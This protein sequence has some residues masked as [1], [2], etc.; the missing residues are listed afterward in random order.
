MVSLNGISA[1]E[2]G[3]VANKTTVAP[4]WTIQCGT[5][6]SLVVQVVSIGV[7]SGGIFVPYK[8]ASINTDVVK[9]R[10]MGYTPYQL[11]QYFLE[12]Y[13]ARTEWG[14]YG[15]NS[16]ISTS[17]F[18]GTTYITDENAQFDYY[19]IKLPS[20]QNNTS[21]KWDQYADLRV[22]DSLT[23][24]RKHASIVG[25]YG[26]KKSCTSQ[27][28][29]SSSTSNPKTKPQSELSIYYSVLQFPYA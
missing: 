12:A 7:G 5:G 15:S 2:G 24:Q 9:E 19:A 27:I 6:D 11:N 16:N 3:L 29:P 21:E 28:W 14:V 8:G 18:S 26:S 17:T 1:S 4:E 22:Y 20:M 13:G 25:T 10:Y 23:G